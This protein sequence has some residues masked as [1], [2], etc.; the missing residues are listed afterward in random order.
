MFDL[1]YK[2]IHYYCVPHK[3]DKFI[4]LVSAIP[5]EPSNNISTYSAYN[6]TTC[7]CSSQDVERSMYYTCIWKTM[8]NFFFKNKEKKRGFSLCYSYFPRIVLKPKIRTKCHLDL[9]MLSPCD[10]RQGRMCIIDTH[11]HTPIQ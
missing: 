4:I 10:F 11:T 9:W 2:T 3:S 5:S 7:S 8:G 6:I 1:S